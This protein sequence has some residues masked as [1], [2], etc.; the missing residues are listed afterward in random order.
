MEYSHLE[1]GSKI[2][3]KLRCSGCRR[4]LFWVRKEGLGII[5]RVCPHTDC[6]RK[7][8]FLLF[9]GKACVIN[10]KL[11]KR[12]HIMSNLTPELRESITNL[13]IK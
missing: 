9:N 13:V 5:E 11:L 10:K 7:T 3:V 4:T 2:E 8:A 6:K 1:V 12:K